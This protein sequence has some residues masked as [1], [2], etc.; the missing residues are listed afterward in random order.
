MEPMKNFANQTMWTGDNLPILRG[1]NSKSIDL[2]YLD[3][4]FNSKANYAA[5]IGSKA[6]GAEF[7]DTWSL[8]DVDSE[9]INLIDA[10]HPALYRVLLAA[11]NASD[12]SYLVY[13]AARLL[14]LHRILKDTGSIYLHCDPT[15]SHYL[16]LV[17]DAIFGRGN[18]RNEIVWQRDVPGKGAKRI[19]HQWPRN[20]DVILFYTR[21]QIAYFKQQYT[22]LSD[23]QKKPYRYTDTHGKY[24][25]V[26]RGDYSDAS[27]ERFRL[28]DR[29]HTSRTGKEYIKYYLQD[30][31]A[32]I[33]NV[34]TDVLGFGTRTAA[35]ER[36]GYPTQKPLECLRRIV[37]A[38]CPESGIVLDPFAGCATTCIAAESLERQW[39]GIDI[40]PLAVQLVE[41][42]MKDE[43]GLFYQGT[44]RTDRPMRTD[45]GS[46]PS[47]HTHRTTLYGEQGGF[48]N[49][50]GMHFQPQHLEVDHIIAR[51]VGGTDHIENLQLLCGACN[52][53]KGARGM[54]YLR[55]KLG[56]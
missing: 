38:S 35:K 16:K 17:M 6:A 1:I 54:E 43:L 39:I 51:A 45:F 32:T 3:P 25:A 30:A 24:K 44:P 42:R 10:K 31:R 26:Q 55:V 27:M 33:G 11:M 12:K 4:P 18:F 46:L 41:R 19:S 52:K 36:L 20:H 48:C 49:G 37:A 47:P 34:W 50:C 13:M 23:K 15:M 2:I 8:S 22:D 28:Q 7:K 9:W 56:L 21:E 5:P 40:S 53:I 14:E 29:I